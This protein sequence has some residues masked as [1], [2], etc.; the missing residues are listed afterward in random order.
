MVNKI[1][2]KNTH[3]GSG[4]ATSDAATVAAGDMMAEILQGFLTGLASAEH[5]LVD[6]NRRGWNYP[7][8][9]VGS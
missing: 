1:D 9:L 4:G 8:Q 3:N 2:A 5:S 6:E 7:L